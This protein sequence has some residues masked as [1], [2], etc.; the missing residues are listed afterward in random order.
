VY[1]HQAT[2]IERGVRRQLGQGGMASVYLARQQSMN[3]NVALKILPRALM[4]DDSYLQRFERE[5]KI[6][7]QDGTEYTTKTDA[8]GD[9]K[10]SGI[11][12]GRY[13]IHISKEGYG[14]RLGKAVTIVN[15]GDHFVPLK[16]SKM[17]GSHVEP[18]PIRM[19]AV[20]K[21]RIEFLLQRVTESVGKRYDLDEG[22]VK[23]LHK[24][25]LDSIDS[26]L[27]KA[28]SRSAFAKAL[29]NSNAVLLN[30]LLARP[31]CKAA[32]TEHLS[33]A[34]FQDYLDFAAARQ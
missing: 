9:Y 10:K 17:D 20:V 12:A 15:G 6:V 24:S 8:N 11:P 14:K 32:F 33:A 16:M 23:A 25:I 5:V 21:M 31:A 1:K 7:A 27:L 18:Q 30:V 2:D 29:D 26:V 3:R 13:L 28:E 4:R 34:Q 19:D 22:A